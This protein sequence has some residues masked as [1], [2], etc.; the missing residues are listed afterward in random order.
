MSFV[1]VCDFWAL[2]SNKH[3]EK[4]RDRDREKVEHYPFQIFKIHWYRKK[5]ALPQVPWQD[6]HEDCF[7]KHILL[8]FLTLLKLYLTGF[9][10]RKALGNVFFLS[11]SPLSLLSL[12]L[13]LP[14]FPLLPSYSL[15]SLPPSSTL[16]SYLE[17]TILWLVCCLCAITSFSEAG[18]NSLYAHWGVPSELQVS[19][20]TWVGPKGNLFP[21]K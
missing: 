14:F 12:S 4:D 9:V 20:W 15:F 2:G 18:L 17:I 10:C 13:F 5:Q 3:T 11:S 8:D 19:T 21:K 1:T 6:I 7:K 16:L